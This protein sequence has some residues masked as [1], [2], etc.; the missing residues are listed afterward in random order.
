MQCKATRQ[1]KQE[2]KAFLIF[3]SYFFCKRF[4]KEDKVYARAKWLM[5]PSF[6]R[7]PKHEATRN[8]TPPPWIGCQSISRLTIRFQ[9]ATT[10]TLFLRIVWRLQERL[11]NARCITKVKATTMTNQNGE[12]DRRVPVKWK[13]KLVERNFI[14]S[15]HKTSMNDKRNI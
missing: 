15:P 6:S 9:T 1:N 7:F 14:C 12:K 3:T 2:I 4:V 10:Y 13:K 8:I 11:S 5:S